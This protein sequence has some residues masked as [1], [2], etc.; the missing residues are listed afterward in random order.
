MNTTHIVS[1][2]EPWPAT[3]RTG[4]PCDADIELR[5][6]ER[7]CVNMQRRVLSLLGKLPPAIT[8]DELLDD[9]V[10][11]HWAT[12]LGEPKEKP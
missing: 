11:V 8:D 10:A 7:D 12:R 2:L 9:F 6:T 1:W 3:D 4:K 5:A